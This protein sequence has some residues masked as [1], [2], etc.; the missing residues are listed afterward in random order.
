MPKREQLDS[1]QAFA[2]AGLDGPAA[3]GGPTAFGLVLSVLPGGP[4]IRVDPGGQAVSAG[5]ACTRLLGAR[6]QH[7][8]GAG[9]Q[10]EHET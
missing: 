3:T 4:L 1:T 8:A 10:E 9:L 2:P 5:I 6:G 7:R